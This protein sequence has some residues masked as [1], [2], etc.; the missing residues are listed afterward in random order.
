MAKLLFDEPPISVSPTLASMFADLGLDGLSAVAYIQQINMSTYIKACQPEKYKD[1]FIDGYFWCY[2]SYAEWVKLFPFFGCTKTLQRLSKKLEDM[3][4]IVSV[5]LAKSLDRR[6]RTR[7]DEDVLEELRKAYLKKLESQSGGVS[8]AHRQFVRKHDVQNVPMED[9]QNVADH[10]DKKSACNTKRSSKGSS[11]GSNQDQHQCAGV[12]QLPLN[13]DVETA[14]GPES[15]TNKPSIKHKPAAFSKVWAQRPY[16]NDNKVPAIRAWNAAALSDEDINNLLHYIALHKAKDERW[17]R[18]FI[19]MLS[20]I[21]NQRRWEDEWEPSRPGQ[22]P[23]GPKRGA[24]ALD[25]TE[26]DLDTLL[27]A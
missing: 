9:A 7:V 16:K 24:S 21:L 27:N 20:T 6:N 15:E 10:E 17:H 22:P 14:T 19:P 26:S 11:K 2:N 25:R 4:V 1:D 5:Q 13:L 18:G 12:D 23:P 3:G 8:H